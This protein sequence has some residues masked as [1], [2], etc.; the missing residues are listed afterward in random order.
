MSYEIMNNC[1]ACGSCAD[2][3]QI[4][5]IKEDGDKYVIDQE[6]C[7]ECGACFY[8]CDVDAIEITEQ[9]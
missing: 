6:I 1:T 7:A 9:D 4:G 5:A 2:E 3:C 8:I